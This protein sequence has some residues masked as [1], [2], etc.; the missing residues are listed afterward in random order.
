MTAASTQ[1]RTAIDI[2][3]RRVAETPDQ[4]AFRHRTSAGWQ[5]LTWNE[6]DARAREIGAGFMA[7]GL[8]SGDAVCIL[9]QSRLEWVLCEVGA[10]LA[11]G[12]GVPIYPSSTAEQCAY[13][14][15]DAGARIVVVEDAVQ[16]EKV[17][18]LT[19]QVFGFKI[20]VLS[21]RDVPLEKADAAG[22]TKVA[23]GDV[24]AAAGGATVAVQGLDALRAAG[25][26]YLEKSRDELERRSAKLGPDDVFTIIYTSGT[27]GQPKGVELTHGN[28]A[29][30]IASACRALTIQASD[31]HFFFL[32]LAHVLGREMV[33]APILVGAP[34]SFAEGL[35]RI[36][37]NLVEVRPTFM[38]GVPRIFEKFY[39][40]VQA[41]AK[42]GSAVKRALVAWAFSVGQRY[43]ARL[44]AGKGAGPILAA[45][46]ALADKLVLAKLRAKLGLDRCRFLISGGAPLAPEIAAFFHGAGLLILEGYGLTE[47]T[48]AAFVNRVNRYRFGT[49]GPAIDV[50][51]AKIADDGEILMRGPTIFPRYHNNPEATAEVIDRDGW[52]HSGDI[53]V[54]EDGF[55]RI[56]DRKKDLIVSA[57]GKKVAPQMV[58]NG[59][60]AGSSLIGQAVVLGDRQPYCVALMSLSEE[61]VKRFGGGD[62]AR[63]AASP[64]VRAAL[65][66]DVDKLN[67]GLAPF[68]QVKKFAILPADLTEAEGELTPSLKVKRRVVTEKYAALIASLYA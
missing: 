59:L 65:Q 22:R 36:K 25:R 15:R 54:L 4:A 18:P 60:K 7:L 9:S 2:W 56:T 48:S 50:V 39:A 41:G 52:F 37:D 5:P 23:Y 32:P 43:A 38:A 11:G 20:V 17:L 28:L 53:G 14:V 64:E 51:E 21:E 8:K 29:A 31:Q 49:V 68:E 44:R 30:S 58:E 34:T 26:A 3:K 35:T 61:A 57:G 27:T 66:K 19:K 45:Q 63:A 67:A 24:V 1:P 62:Y 13:I 47:T 16:L 42:Q 55:L 6:A 40:G 12:V 33:W 46:H 10:L